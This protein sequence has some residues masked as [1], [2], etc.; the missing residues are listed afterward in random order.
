VLFDF[1]RDGFFHRNTSQSDP[2]NLIPSPV[3]WHGLPYRG[4]HAETSAALEREAT[5]YG[6]F[7]LNA[8]LNA[9]SG[10]G[11]IVGQRADSLLTNTIPVTAGSTY[12]AKVWIKSSTMHSN[13]ELT[14]RVV[15]Q[16]DIEQAASAVFYPETYW[17]AQ[18]LTFTAST[19][20]THV[21]IAVMKDA[22]YDAMQI[23]LAGMMLVAGSDAPSY[24]NSGS[25]LHWRDP[26]TSYVTAL[27][28]SDGMASAYQGMAQPS[29]LT[30]SLSNTTG[31]WLP[32][33][34]TSPFA[35]ALAKGTLV[36]VEADHGGVTYPLWQG[37]VAQYAVS[38]DESAP[39]VTLTLDDPMLLLL[40]TTFSPSLAQGVSTGAALN[41][42]FEEGL[43]RY[44]YPGEFGTLDY[45]TLDGDARLFADWLSD[46]DAGQ[47]VLAY[48]GD[49]TASDAAGVGAQ[50]YI[51]DMV[52]AECGGRFA[53][54]ARRGV[55]VF[56]D[57]H[58]DILYDGT[59]TALTR[60]AG[61]L[62]R[63]DYVWGD[64]LI[65]ELAVGYVPR[66]VGTPA[67]VMYTLPDTPLRFAPNAKR[68]FTAAY[69]VGDAAYVGGIDMILPVPGIDYAALSEDGNKV[70]DVGT[71]DRTSD[72]VVQ[73]EFGAQSAKITI[74]NGGRALYLTLFQLRG[75]P[76]LADTRQTAEARDSAS[77]AAHGLHRKALEL[78]ALSDGALAEQYARYLV[79]RY[80]TP[81]GRLSSIA[82]PAHKSDT[83]MAK[84]LTLGFGD[85]VTVT[86][87]YLTNAQAA[88]VVVGRRHVFDIGGGRHEATLVLQPRDR[89]AWLI[90]DDAGALLDTAILAL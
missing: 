10:A 59:E 67:S 58:R 60:A 45:S 77:V 16:A 62:V 28:F 72:L 55:F 86:D 56:H 18:T 71:Q 70:S 25:A 29:R 38:V 53:Y 13:T 34:A 40:D 41:A 20:S 1:D 81:I 49:N 89:R 31:A 46:F 37:T 78:S 19:G 3:L 87:N 27:E 61:D 32:E 35:S 88:Y 65:N 76:L 54:D 73:V 90:L 69:R 80:K 21:R 7:V 82:I 2:L 17:A 75:T 47:T 15:N 57:R 24:F 23:S 85:F 9:A 42:L 66:R 11:V 6:V 4:A 74:T 5:A 8:E 79:Q 36:L 68:A 44:P 43:L 39:F 26:I 50:A 64:D 51:A 63:A 12:T 22:P 48:V 84:A 83:L 33:N 14:L 52:A 30:L